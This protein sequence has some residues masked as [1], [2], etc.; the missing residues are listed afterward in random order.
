MRALVAGT[1]TIAHSGLFCGAGG[2][3][4]GCPVLLHLRAAGLRGQFPATLRAA[5]EPIRDKR[6]PAD[7]ARIGIALAIMAA[8]TCGLSNRIQHIYGSKAFGTRAAAYAGMCRV[9]RVPKLEQFL[10]AMFGRRAPRE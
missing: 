2:K 10:S 7:F 3:G 4:F 8:L 1:D 9:L 5:L 6:I